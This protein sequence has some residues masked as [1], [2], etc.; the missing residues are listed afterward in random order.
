MS[1][2]EN[3]LQ[4]ALDAIDAIHHQDPAG[5]ELAY[6]DEIERWMQR[7]LGS[8]DTTTRFAARCQHLER[9]AVPRDRF[10]R[11][12]VG[13]NRWRLAIHDH[14]GEVAERVLLEAGVDA[15]IAADVR[16]LVAKKRPRHPVGQAL[17]DAACLYFLD[18]QAE[19]FMA[20]K[21]YDDAKMIDIIR[22]TWRKMS[23]RGRDLA[24]AL[25]TSERLGALVE[26]AVADG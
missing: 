25:P 15:E 18:R 12:R 7:I 6:A 8:L 24:L 9:W 14:Q 16:E 11:G 17:E 5:K 19:T 22:K 20:E 13:Y 4:R 1:T 21:G 10:E 3:T 2:D 23:P 26:A